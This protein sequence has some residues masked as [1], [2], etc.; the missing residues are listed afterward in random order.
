MTMLNSRLMLT[1]DS[2]A[3]KELLIEQLRIEISQMQQ[4]VHAIRGVSE[5]CES[6]RALA[7]QTWTAVYKV[8]PEEEDL[9]MQELE[10]AR[11]DAYSKVEMG[12]PE[13]PPNVEPEEELVEDS[14]TVEVVSEVVEEE[15]PA[16]GVP[17]DVLLGAS[18]VAFAD[19]TTNTIETD[20]E[21]LLTAT[22]L[23]KDHLDFSALKKLA[24]S[25][26]VSAR[27]RLDIESELLSKGV[28]KAQ[29]ND[30]LNPMEF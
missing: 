25:L 8:C 15:S 29:L 21:E 6:L 28:T 5:L 9:I 22:D 20:S 13:L 18:M 26:G 30:V 11:I 23:D 19:A 14:L 10:Q 4:Q 2:I 17:E 16:D 24:A 27:R 3:Q 7:L 1:E 12:I